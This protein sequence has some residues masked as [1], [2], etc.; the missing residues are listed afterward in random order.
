M[1]M[2]RGRRGGCAAIIH[3]YSLRCQSGAK[4]PRLQLGRGFDRV[5]GQE[6]ENLHGIT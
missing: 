1:G 5:D 2:G 6:G 4:G 3:L